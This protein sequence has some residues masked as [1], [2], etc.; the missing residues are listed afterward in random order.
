M[1]IP[2]TT[3]FLSSSKSLILQEIVLCQQFVRKLAVTPKKQ[4][5]TV[6]LEKLFPHV[7]KTGHSNP[8]IAKMVEVMAKER[9]P[10]DF[11]DLRDLNL[12]KKY[13][14]LT[15][16]KIVNKSSTIFEQVQT[17]HLSSIAP[18]SEKGATT[19]CGRRLEDPHVLS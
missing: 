10:S 5:K 1:R 8:E 16:D 7:V 2:T 13:G 17:G 9:V 4:K 18:Q 19:W 12:T 11:A 15:V 3:K 6:S 14:T